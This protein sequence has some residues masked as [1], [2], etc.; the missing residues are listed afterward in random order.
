MFLRSV[1]LRF[2]GGFCPELLV[3]VDQD[4]LSRYG[5]SF[6]DLA[7]ALYT[8]NQ[9]IPSGVIRTNSK[10]IFI[11]IAGETLEP[12]KLKEIVIP[13]KRWDFPASA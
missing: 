10:E 5:L 2:L 12:D 4:S 9:N 8:E 3:E 13:K 11:K 6:F 1:M 7:Q